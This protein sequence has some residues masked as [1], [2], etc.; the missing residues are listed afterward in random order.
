MVHVALDGGG[1]QAACALVLNG[2][3]VGFRQQWL[4]VSMGCRLL[5]GHDL[6][7]AAT[8]KRTEGM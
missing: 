2:R 7:L 1:V 5:P 3:S 4:G 6:Q 8:E